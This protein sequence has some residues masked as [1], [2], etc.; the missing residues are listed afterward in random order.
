MVVVVTGIR[1]SD[2]FYLPLQ[3][4]EN[5]YAGLHYL[6]EAKEIFEKWQLSGS[7]GLTAVTFLACTQTI[8]AILN[9]QNTC[10]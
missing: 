9:F 10:K 7:I 1:K 8:G 4:T 6:A 5:H 3:F 2:P